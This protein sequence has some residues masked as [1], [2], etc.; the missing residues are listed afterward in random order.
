[1]DNGLDFE[2]TIRL[3]AAAAGANVMTSG[4][5]PAEL[6]AIRELESRVRFEYIS[7]T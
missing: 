6:S 7:G 3:A 5:Q 4:S 2:S 1:M